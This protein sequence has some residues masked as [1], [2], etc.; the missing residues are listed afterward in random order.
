MRA[1][2]TENLRDVIAQ[3]CDV[4]SDATDAELAEVTQ[5]LPDLR[6][7]QIELFS[8]RLRRDGLDSGGVK[9]VQATKVNTQPARC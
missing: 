1:V 2:E 4:V 8:Q 7:V 3:I 5:I 9:G 6:G